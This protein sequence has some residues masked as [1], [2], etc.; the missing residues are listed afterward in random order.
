MET[1]LEHRVIESSDVLVRRE[2]SKVKYSV[3]KKKHSNRLEVATLKYNKYQ[4]VKVYHDCTN[5]EDPGFTTFYDEFHDRHIYVTNKSVGK[6]QAFHNEYDIKY[7]WNVI[8]PESTHAHSTSMSP[9]LRKWFDV[10]IRLVCLQMFESE[11]NV[12]LYCFNG[13][14]RSP[15]YLVAY[16]VL[17]CDMS[18]D[19]A[20][21]NVNA[22]LLTKRN[23]RLDRH[24]CLYGIVAKI[25]ELFLLHKVLA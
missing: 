15:M 11:G 14:S 21:F 2:L 25:A 6:S 4:R 24:Y 5:S 19:R 7:A 3:L 8:H 10:N 16:F 18:L 22:Q 20:M 12:V 23:E 9:H 13:R 17:F 1:T